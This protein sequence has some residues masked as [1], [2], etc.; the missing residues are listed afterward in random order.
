MK[1]NIFLLVK[2]LVASFMMLAFNA[3]QEEIP[4]IPP[5]SQDD[6]W[7]DEEEVVVD[8]NSIFVTVAGAGTKDGSSWDNAYG[9][10]EFVAAL[11]GGDDSK[12]NGK[13]FYLASGDYQ[14]ATNS[15]VSVAFEEKS[16][17]FNVR[18]GFSTSSTGTDLNSASGT[19]RLLRSTDCSNPD[20][21]AQ[22]SM[23]VLGKN[24]KMSMVN[25]TLD[26]QYTPDDNGTM[27]ALYAADAVVDFKNC[28]ITNWNVKGNTNASA[29]RAGAILL[30]GNAEAYFDNCT[31]SYNTAND[32]GGAIQAAGTNTMFFNK[33][34]FHNNTAKGAWGTAIHA[35]GGHI[36]INN[37]TFLGGEGGGSNSLNVVINS[38]S[39]CLVVNS[40]IIANAG[41]PCGALR[42][43][44]ASITPSSM[45]INSLLS[46]GDGELVFAD[47]A[48]TQYVKSGGFNVYYGVNG[49]TT[50]SFTP[51]TTDTDYSAM[52][53][54][55]VFVETGT[56][57]WK[58]VDSQI[59]KFGTVSEIVSTMAGSGLPKVNDFISWCGG[60]TA[61]LS[62][63]LGNDRNSNKMRPGAYEGE[64][65]AP[66]AEVLALNLN[67]K[68]ASLKALSADIDNSWPEGA[69]AGVYTTEESSNVTM[70]N[71]SG[72]A[73]TADFTG[74]AKFSTK[75][76]TTV[77]AYYP[78]SASAASDPAALSFN[79]ASTQNPTA[80]SYDP[81]YAV[82]AAEAKSVDAVAASA[83]NVEISGMEFKSKVAVVAVKG[84]GLTPAMLN[85]APLTSIVVRA[86]AEDTHKFTGDAVLDLTTGAL[87]AGAKGQNSVQVEY[88]IE[89]AIQ[90]GAQTAYFCVIPQTLKAGDVVT[91]EFISKGEYTVKKE[92]ALPADLVL[93]TDKV[94]EITVDA[95]AADIIWAETE[96]NELYASPAGAGLKNGRNW[97]NAFGTAELVDYLNTLDS[98]KEKK[99]YL[100]SGE[101]VVVDY[102]DETTGK[103]QGVNITKP[104]KLT[105]DGG[106]SASS[107]G[108]DLTKKEG[109]TVI[110]RTADSKKCNDYSLI[111]ITNVDVNMTVKNC[112]FDGKYAMED[113]GLFRA[114]YLYGASA[115]AE[116]HMENCEIKNFNIAG[117]NTGSA[118]SRGG[119]IRVNRGFLYLDNVTVHENK[120]HSRGGALLIENANSHLFMNNCLFYGNAI[121][122]AWGIS[123]HANSGKLCI[124]NSTFLS[125]P[126]VAGKIQ[127]EVNGDANALV[128]NSTVIANE[129]V[130]AGTVRFNNAANGGIIVNSLFSQGKGS[131]CFADRAEINY[132]KP[133]G[134]CVY[135]G[136]LGG[137]T[138]GVTPC[139]T[140]SDYTGVSWT[141]PTKEVFKWTVDE[142]KQKAYATKDAVM[143]VVKAHQH[144]EEFI[145]W[146]GGE[147]A[148]TVDQLGNARNASKM[149]PGAYDA[150]LK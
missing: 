58:P 130:S 7:D 1:K 33:C 127:V 53:L 54:P 37:S 63:Q 55:G 91:V 17:E 50:G 13:K 15:Q 110:T 81:A 65:D 145:N 4:M 120:A 66:V 41:Y 61:F 69:K 94:N 44:C 122:D 62:D 60:Q 74:K 34:F 97:D 29:K 115:A 48:E 117:N 6:G 118:A 99:L 32:R 148:F 137:S 30:N 35:G 47:R 103:L 126:G 77:Y 9:C 132:I 2:I 135:E 111:R 108:S 26:G 105:L 25:C 123:I 129:N 42:N 106:Y 121:N 10:A 43:N 142:G 125:A 116:L 64:A 134:Y 28:V 87:T 38:D 136:V 76:A 11:T 131:Y 144:G 98:V 68:G 149:Q 56:Y 83:T 150:G 24:V 124:N 88:K 147:G 12:V 21:E 23:I 112:V 18:G 14:L 51:A 22:F 31:V 49:G 46:A 36:C 113:L 128:V 80:A 16:V 52:T 84:A 139:E 107:T 78:Y 73:K 5:P 104:N 95:T 93:S 19:T 70:T 100:K 133:S 114:I 45:V 140:D 146:L 92:V 138:G 143:T 119:A 90:Y 79:I 20:T 85:N 101:Y 96:I 39:Q 3:C 27:R 8:E 75:K 67:L 89:D 40:T 102:V 59:T 57:M 109:T 82:Y 86:G 141:Y 71:E 72:A